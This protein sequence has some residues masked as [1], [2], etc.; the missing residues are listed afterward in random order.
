MNNKECLF[1]RI[2]Q[3]RKETF[4]YEDDSVVVLLSKYQ[5]SKGHLI[6]TLKNHFESIDDIPEQDYLHLQSVIKKYN[7]KLN[8]N[9]KPEKIYILLL[10]EEVAHV[11]FSVIPRYEGDTKGPA[12][13]TENITELK[14]P[15]IL[16]G[17][18]TL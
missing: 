4:V 12:F 1:C 7:Q 16:I 10:A 5:T 2:I 9:L 17:Q 3:N 15:E 18:I 11:H 14:N 6:I 8:S 13:L